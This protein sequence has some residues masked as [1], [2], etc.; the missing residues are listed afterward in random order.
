ML[1]VHTYACLI[2]LFKNVNMMNLDELDINN[3]VV[4]FCYVQEV[5]VKHILTAL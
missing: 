5:S 4:L 3:F 1:T 2:M